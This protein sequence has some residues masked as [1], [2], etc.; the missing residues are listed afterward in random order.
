MAGLCPDVADIDSVLSELVHLQILA[1]QSSRLSSEFGRYS[2]GQSMFRSVAYATLSLRE[3][4]KIHLA[5]VD[6]YGPEADLSPDHAAVLAQHLLDAIETVPGDDDVDICAP[7][8][9]AS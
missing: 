9:S 3:R 2:F 7:A 1:H 4:K 6:S 5:I 8:P